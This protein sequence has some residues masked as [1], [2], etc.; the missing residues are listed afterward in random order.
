[1]FR[2]RTVL[3]SLLMFA[4]CGGGSDAPSFDRTGRPELPV[5]LFW[6][7]ASAETQVNDVTVECS[8]DYLVDI[9]GEVARTDDVVEYVGTMGGEARRSLLNPD[10]SGVAIMADAF[11]E[12]QVL[13][14]VPD[15]VQINQINLPPD[16]PGASSRFWDEQRRFDGQLGPGDLMTGEWVCAPLDTEIGGIVDD[17]ISADGVWYSETATR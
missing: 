12:V 5:L 10:Q 13:L 4:G 11:S 1:M 15:R 7:R 16:P 14:L 8:L 17:T 6:L 2:M 3:V 9:A